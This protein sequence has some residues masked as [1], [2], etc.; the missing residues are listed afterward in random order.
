MP[1]NKNITLG[2]TQMGTTSKIIASIVGAFL[3]AA[4]G[5]GLYQDLN[6]QPTTPSQ[7]EMA[8]HMHDRANPVVDVGTLENGIILKACMK[9]GKEVTMAAVIKGDLTKDGKTQPLREFVQS[10]FTETARSHNSTDETWLKDLAAAY[11]NSTT[12][13][14]VKMSESYHAEMMPPIVSGDTCTLK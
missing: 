6:N 1:F 2:E 12:G 10:L 11:V 9:D 8:A 4:G 5:A 3:I 13:N 14:D 7:D